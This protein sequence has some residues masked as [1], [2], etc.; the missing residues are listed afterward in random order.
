ML[1]ESVEL[2]LGFFIVV[3]SSVHSNSDSSWYVSYSFRPEEGVQRLINLYFLSEHFLLGK[4]D[5]F[6]NSSWCSLLELN[7]V[8]GFM[9]VDGIVSSSLMDF[10][11]LSLGHF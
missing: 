11:S 7:S 5:E 4:L 2:F 9:K 10:F 1:D 6:S 8:E 3:L